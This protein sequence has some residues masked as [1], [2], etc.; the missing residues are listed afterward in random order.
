MPA[1]NILAALLKAGTGFSIGGKQ[2]LRTATQSILFTSFHIP[3]LIEG[4]PVSFEQ[5]DA[6]DGSFAEHCQQAR[7]LGFRLFV[8]P[9][10][11]GT[12]SHVRVRPCFDAW[13]LETTFETDDDDL[14]GGEDRLDSLWNI[15]GRKAGLGD[16]RP[17]APKKPGVYGRF[18]AT[19]T[20]I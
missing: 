10:T 7:S 15:A 13:S 12:A 9:A 4:K 6:I 2:T 16:W 14:L 1:E 18:K 5:I 17:S 20:K 19:V 11:I 3:L 8:K